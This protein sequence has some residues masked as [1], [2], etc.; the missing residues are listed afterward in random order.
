MLF[1]KFEKLP[2]DKKEMILS[3]GI[4]EFS[5]KKVIEM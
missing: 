2:E 5:Q 1:E 3:V 4:K